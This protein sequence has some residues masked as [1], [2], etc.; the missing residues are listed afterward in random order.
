[1]SGDL[2]VFPFASGEVIGVFP[3]GGR[4]RWSSVVAGRRPGSASALTVSGI[5]GDP[6]I[7]DGRVY[8]GNASGRISALD[9]FT[10]ETIWSVADGALGPVVPAGDAL[11][12]INDIGQLQRLDAATGT[13]VWRTDLPQGE[14]AG[15]LRRDRPTAHYGPILAGGR[16]L[17][18]SSDG[19]IR[20]ADPVSG[21]LLGALPLEGGA[22]SAPIAAGGVL[23]VV[24]TDGALA[25]FR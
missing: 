16:L 24:T 12:L 4:S 2:A 22:A 1:M 10:G 14:A 9:G 13:T 15:F 19:V 18:A 25:A 8:V 20:Q 23:Y 7:E 17:I 3:E 21:R 11:F 6:V 5:S